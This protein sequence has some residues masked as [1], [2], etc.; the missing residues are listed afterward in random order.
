[1]PL[2]STASPLPI[3]RKIFRHR[4]SFSPTNLT[5]LSLWLKGDAGIT[6]SGSNVTAWADQSGNAKNA[7]ATDTPTL[8]TIGGKTFV[9]FAGGFF[10]GDEILTQEYG[11]IMVVANFTT[12]RE[13]AVIFQQ[14]IDDGD[15]VALYR[16]HNGGTLNFAF[17]SGVGLGSL[18][19]TSNN[20]T[21]L[22]GVTFDA[23]NGQL[24]LNSNTDEAGYI[25]GNNIGGTYYIGKW[26]SG[27]V[28]TTEMRMAE[29]VIYNRVLTT[30]ERQQV[31]AYLNAK[32]TIY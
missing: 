26:V 1:V 22:Y 28:V 2:Y 9:D 13:V 5:G 19:E 3:N 32:Y 17:Y 29:I 15:A 24:Y 30:P 23:S 31:E 7:T 11:T 18:A 8:T 6:L 4:V 16:G 12:G 20:Q 21:Y 25:G 27:D 10:T 14:F